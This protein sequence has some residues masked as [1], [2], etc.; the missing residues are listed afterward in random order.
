MRRI[1][2]KLKIR[3]NHLRH[4]SHYHMKVQLRNLI[5]ISLLH[6]RV[7]SKTGTIYIITRLAQKKVKIMNLKA[8]WPN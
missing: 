1:S 6:T 7:L 8:V 4:S 3:N 2:W 5:S